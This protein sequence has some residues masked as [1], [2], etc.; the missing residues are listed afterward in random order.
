M[1]RFEAT[2]ISLDSSV[3]VDFHLTGSTSTLEQLFTRRMLMSDLVEEE[4]D[5]AGIKVFGASVIALTTDEQWEFFA[6]LRTKRPG[7]GLGELG[8]L[9]VARFEDITL[10]TNDRLARQAAEENGIPVSGAIGA[11]EFAVE[12]GSLEGQDAVRILRGNDSGGRVDLE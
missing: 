12:N 8:A 5:A 10:L 7:L 6:R 2:T 4:L 9:T 11:L 3:V 1:H